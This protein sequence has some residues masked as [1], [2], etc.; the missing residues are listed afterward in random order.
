M[1]ALSK[2]ARCWGCEI[3]LQQ[4]PKNDDEQ[5]NLLNL[6]DA[7][8]MARQ[9]HELLEVVVDGPLVVE[10]HK[11]PD[12]IVGQRQPNHGFTNCTNRF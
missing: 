5:L 1:M 3:D 12:R 4:L 2:V 7:C 9:G 10:K 8:V 6:C 11:L